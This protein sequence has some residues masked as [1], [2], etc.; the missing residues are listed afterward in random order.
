MTLLAAAP[1]GWKCSLPNAG[2]TIV[3]P[4]FSDL[5]QARSPCRLHPADG[6]AAIEPEVACVMA[7]DLAPRAAPYAE[8]EV[9]AAVGEVRLVLEL[10]GC[11]YAE[12]AGLPFNE[13]LA[14]NA[15]NQGLFVGPAVA[16][17]WQRSFAE[18][19]LKV[20]ADGETIIE[21]DGRHPDGDPLRPLTWLANELC[22]SRWG[23]R[24]LKTGRS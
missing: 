13:M 4:I 23:G 19:A 1:G 5:L 24:G 14:D 15:S 11:R 12:P 6:M 20:A 8:D 18:I 21:R 9:R 17:P 7:R 3:A 16:D 22:T 2:K 10:I